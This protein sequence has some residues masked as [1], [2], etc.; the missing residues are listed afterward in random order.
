MKRNDLEEKKKLVYRVMREGSYVPMKEKELIILLQVKPEKRLIFKQVLNELLAEGK[1]EISKRGKY[2]AKILSRGK[3]KES[4]VRTAKD[5][6]PKPVSAEKTTE[7]VP[8]QIVGIYE[9][10]HN[11]GFVIPDMRKTSADVFIPTGLSLGAFDGHKVIV[12]ITKQGS[13]RRNPEGKIIE[14]IGHVNDPGTDVLSI[15]KAF[16]LPCEFNEK[17]LNQAERIGLYVTDADMAGRKDLRGVMMVTIDGADAK[18]LDD[19]ISIHREGENFRLGVH[20]ADVTNYVQENSALDRE[21]KQRGTSV[22]LAD[23]VI[24][25]LP[26][27]LSNGICS[28]NAGVDRLSLSCMM[29]VSPKGDVLEHEIAETVIK[30]DRRMTYE[31][32]REILED[33]NPVTTAEHH[34]F[35][36]MFIMMEELAACLRQKRKKRGSIDFDF[37]ES[38]ILVDENGVPYDV[39]PYLSNTATKIIEEFMLLANETV[40]THFNKLKSP[41]VYRTH[42]DPEPDKIEQLKITLGNFGFKTG[43]SLAKDPKVKAVRKSSKTKE[44]SRE[45]QRLSAQTIKIHPREIQKILKQAAGT[46]Y[47]ATINRLAL[48]SMKRAEYSPDE[49]THF[50]LASPC[51]C[52]FTSPIRRYPDLQIHRII[53]EHLRGQFTKARSNHYDG[54][55]AET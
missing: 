32:V 19:A 26:H 48:R 37:P 27:A 51:Y 22:Y 42:A 14:I 39:K 3:S 54:L 10:S 9:K 11:F 43:G 8:L 31:A 46:P 16:G 21:A 24:P 12:E 49:T 6:V 7:R 1:I 55:L 4:K 15:V 40:A 52:H 30:I 47:E 23:R 18:D 35:H 53:K 17:T 45:K 36:D 41:F 13:E 38:K 33:K 44:K 20:I 29:L 2:S 25:M 50:G 5:V 34:E 28:L